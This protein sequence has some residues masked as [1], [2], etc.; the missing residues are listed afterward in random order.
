MKE[1]LLLKII[2]LPPSSRYAVG[3][4][5]YLT[6][7]VD[8]HHPIEFLIAWIHCTIQKIVTVNIYTLSFLQLLI[9]AV[10][11]SRGNKKNMYIY[12]YNDA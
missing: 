8:E 3:E 2:T 4:H 12:L 9:L 1:I 10:V 5:F 7:I 11:L 6:V